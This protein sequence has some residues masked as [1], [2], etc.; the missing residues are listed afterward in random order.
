MC[1]T[2]IAV[3]PC[4]T[5]RSGF[6]VRFASVVTNLLMG[7]S[8]SRMDDVDGMDKVDDGTFSLRPR[9]SNRPAAG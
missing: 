9:G 8:P 2:A 3:I 6:S 5:M 7:Y 1:I 4:T